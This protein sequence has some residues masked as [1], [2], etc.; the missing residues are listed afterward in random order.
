M[1]LAIK[2]GSEAASSSCAKDQNLLA[3]VS[4]SSLDYLKLLG[5]TFGTGWIFSTDDSW[6][7]VRD[8]VMENGFS[9]IW[10]AH[11]QQSAH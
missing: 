3:C 1:S 10:Y 6:Y 9:D 11:A 7:Q 2:A 8:S 5:D 4:A